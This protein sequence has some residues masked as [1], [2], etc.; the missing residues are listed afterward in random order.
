MA[1]F[2]FFFLII[3]SPCPCNILSFFLDS[4]YSFILFVQMFT[5]VGK[6]LEKLVMETFLLQI[7][8]KDSVLDRM[9]LSACPLEV[10]MISLCYLLSFPQLMSLSHRFLFINCDL[11]P[12]LCWSSK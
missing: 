11:F 5:F 6:L 12:D 2:N 4:I 7:L 10:V 1:R 3:L 9:I 8:W